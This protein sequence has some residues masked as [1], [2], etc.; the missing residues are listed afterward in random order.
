MAAGLEV[1]IIEDDP[2]DAE[3]LVLELRHAGYQTGWRRVDTQ[4]DF[5]AALAR[6]PDVVISDYSLPGFTALDVLRQLNERGVDVP[7]IVISGVMT[8]DACVEALRHGAVDYLLKDRLTRLGAAIQHALRQ[9]RLVA[10]RR[11]ADEERRRAE[12]ALQRQAEELAR[13][14][15]ELLELDR[16]KR[17]FVATV[18]H[19][20]RTPLTAIRGY[21]EILTDGAGD[22]ASPVLRQIIGKI[23]RNGE[24]LQGL[25]EE[26]LSFSQL[27]SGGLPLHRKP[28]HP[29][30]LVARASEALDAR[31]RAAGITLDVDVPLTLPTLDVDPRQVQR[32]LVHVLSNAI[33]FSP[34][35]GAVVL[36]GR[37]DAGVVVMAVRDHG[38][39]IPEDERERLFTR[40]YRTS[41][42]QS[43]AIG[44]SGLGLA[45]AKAIVDAHEGWIRLDSAPGCGTT[46]TFALPVTP[47]ERPAG[48]GPA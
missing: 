12:E 34:G 19:E 28:S 45:M 46:V 11:H 22:A 3:L 35:G 13:T 10:E 29:A 16:M 47:V 7:T 48:P 6:L 36:S 15:A 21:T 8:E 23:D 41:E 17:D 9:R 14:N 2:E 4:A 20:L 27:D 31:L 25:I 18:S 30:D 43:R 39:G 24:R 37:E 5:V 44:G 32:L 1:L 38:I 42:A 26:L 33:K 40:F